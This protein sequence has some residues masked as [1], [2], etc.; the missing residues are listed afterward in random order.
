MRGKYFV[1]ILLAL[2]ISLLE[3]QYYFSKNKVQYEDFSFKTYETEHFTIYFTEGGEILLEFASRYAEEFYKKLSTDLGFSIKTKIPLVIYNSHN[4]FAQTNIILDIIEEAVGGFSELFKNRIVVPFDGSYENFRRVIEHEITHIFEFEMFYRARLLNLLTSFSDF[5]LPLWIMEG[6]SE[7]LSNEGVYNIEHETYLCD[8]ILHNRYIPL[9]RLTDE[10][11]YI[12]YRLGQAFFDYVSEKYDRKKVFDFMQVLRTKKNLNQTFKTCFGMEI[13]EFSE[14]LEEYLKI[15]YYPQ[16]TKRDNFSRIAQVLVDHKKDNSSYNAFPV[17]SPSGLKVAMV[18]D[19]SGYSDVYVISAIDGR[20]L[21]RLLKGERSGGFE[22]F[23]LLKPALAW[24]PDEKALVVVT[25]SQGKDELVIVKYP[26]GKVI[27][28]LRFPLD[29]LNSPQVSP[30]GHKIVFVGIK[31]GYSDIYL[32]EIN[33]GSLLRLTYDYYDDR[34]PS[35]SPDGKKIIFVSDRPREL[36]WQVGAYRIFELDIAG[37]VTNPNHIYSTAPKIKEFPNL[38]A[39]TYFRPVLSPDGKY[40]IFGASDSANNIY[41]YSTEQNKVV[42]RTDFVGNIQYFSLDT[43]GTKLVFSYLQ[44]L[45][46]NIGLINE[47]LKTIPEISSNYMLS[48]KKYYEFEPTGIESEKITPYRFNL[49]SDYAVGQASYST[50]SGFSGQLT[51]SL[52]DILGN[53]QF[54]LTTDLYQNINNS[55][56]LF[57]YWYLPRRTDWALAFFQYFEYPVISGSY[58]HL[59]RNRG[60]G[61]FLSYP[62][63]KFSRVE[64][65][66]INYFS[67]NETYQRIGNYWYPDESYKEPIVLIDEAFVYDNTIWNDWGPYQGVR[68]RIESYQALP[69]SARRFYTSYFD[70]R[71]YTRITPRY[72]FA[73]RLFNL[74]SLGNDRENY[75]I[76]GE[77]VRGYEYYEFQDQP[78]NILGFANLELRHPFIDKLKLAFPIPLELSNIRGVTFLDLGCAYRTPFVV[79]KSG[80]GFK[81]LKIGAG[82]GLR[83]QISYFLLKLDFAKPLS[84]TNNPGWKWYLSLGTDF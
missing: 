59:R 10:M 36:N 47:P 26:S 69:P 52:S 35:F 32:T 80:E 23:S 41:L 29:A 72:I 6:F 21:K 71:N 48:L 43:A 51:I 28:R 73:T 16:I 63:D 64:L 46:W 66:N 12:N 44:N 76:G 3:A 84:E 65:G 20:I 60:F 74:I 18:S 75:S 14:Q 61:V 79:Y 49:T 62:F 82:F 9:E 56:F 27:R 38:P 31:N 17:I 30:D 83:V 7:F 67:Y 4:Q 81:D 45:G 5:N 42:A 24:F 11:G 53:H 70:L 39:N 57:N 54:Y 15:K 13:G 25:K 58:V 1:I 22:A 37:A 77:I 8:L 34:D 68:L 19:R 33:Q 40:L 2:C 78:S 55:E 50:G